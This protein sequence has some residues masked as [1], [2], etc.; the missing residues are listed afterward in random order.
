MQ[1]ALRFSFV[2]SGPVE[3]GM[4]KFGKGPGGVM[5][6]KSSLDAVELKV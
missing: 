3:W 1:Q 5:K 2:E 6:G 4:C